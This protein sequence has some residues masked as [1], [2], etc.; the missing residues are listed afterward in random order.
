[1][2]SYFLLKTLL[3]E[4]MPEGWPSLIVAIFFLGGI[5][6][7]GIG[8]VGE[9]IARIFIAQNKW[10]QFSVKAVQRSNNPPKTQDVHGR[11]SD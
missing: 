2:G 4:Q 6:L 1:M 11:S 7:M 3:W 5:Q 10:P 9:Y 8:A